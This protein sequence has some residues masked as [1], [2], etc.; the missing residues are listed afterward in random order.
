MSQS[1]TSRRALLTA[2]VAVPAAAV[3]APMIAAPA[4]AA[5][6]PGGISVVQDWQPLVLAAAVTAATDAPAARVVKIAGTD[7][8]QM[9]G[10]FTCAFTADAVLGTLPA[11]ITVPKTMR[12]VCPRNNSL[13][14][15]SCRVE[16]NTAGKITV[17]GATASNDITWVTLD[18]Y[19]VVMA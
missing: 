14:V 9:R 1:R 8:L 11:A 3:S 4:A 2:A 10:G 15:N 7:F 17:F 5:D 13:G 12:G 6:V 18:S 19:S 16:V